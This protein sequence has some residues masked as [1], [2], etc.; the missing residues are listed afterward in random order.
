MFWMLDG[1]LENGLVGI[2]DSGVELL[3]LLLSII[4]STSGWVRNFSRMCD[5]STAVGLASG[6]CNQYSLIAIYLCL[7]ESK[8][9]HLFSCFQSSLCSHLA[10]LDVEKLLHML[11]TLFY[12]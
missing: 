3:L 7:V 12:Y 6:S 2:E 4:L 9:I 5:T 11:Y 1:Q 8:A 10:K